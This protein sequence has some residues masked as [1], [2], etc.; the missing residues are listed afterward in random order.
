VVERVG[1]KGYDY[2]ILKRRKV[3]EQTKMAR[4]PSY[5]QLNGKG[6]SNAHNRTNQGWTRDT[7]TIKMLSMNICPCGIHKSSFF[8]RTLD[9]VK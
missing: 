4:T 2:K 3:V 8:E 1:I 5:E 9:I 7:T 6:E